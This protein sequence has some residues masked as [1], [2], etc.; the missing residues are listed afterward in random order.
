MNLEAENK[1]RLSGEEFDE[2]IGLFEFDSRK[3]FSIEQYKSAKEI[4]P[5]NLEYFGCGT[6]YGASANFLFKCE[7]CA[8]LGMNPS[9]YRIILDTLGGHSYLRRF[10]NKAD[11][12][13]GCDDSN[14]SKIMLDDKSDYQESALHFVKDLGYVCDHCHESIFI[15]NEQ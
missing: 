11:L 13:K 4:H 9:W 6:S 15:E 3:W 5:L 2:L 7:T 12:L 14:L 1:N 10:T 8:S